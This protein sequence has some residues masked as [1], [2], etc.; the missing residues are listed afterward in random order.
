MS[1]DL[2]WLVETVSSLHFFGW[3]EPFCFGVAW[4]LPVST[5]PAKKWWKKYEKLRNRWEGFENFTFWDFQL[6]WFEPTVWLPESQIYRLS[7]KGND[8][9]IV[10]NI[11]VS[12]MWLNDNRIYENKDLPFELVWIG[13]N[14]ND[15]AWWCA[16]FSH[17]TE[18]VM[19]VKHNVKRTTGFYGNVAE[20]WCKCGRW[21][22][23]FILFELERV[24]FGKGVGDFWCVGTA[25]KKHTKPPKN[26]LVGR[27]LGEVTQP[28]HVKTHIKP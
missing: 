27:C 22:L 26:G 10:E 2:K 23:A 6:V 8:G 15:L 13:P 28:K 14:A 25:F 16:V 11:Q 21:R 3:L 17:H 18:S 24:F 20:E 1:L 4:L 7:Q 9:R 12:R 5:E 19:S